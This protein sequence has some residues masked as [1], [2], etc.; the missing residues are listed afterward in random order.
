MDEKIRTK[1]NGDAH[2]EQHR[3]Y[4]YQVVSV[5]YLFLSCLSTK[6]L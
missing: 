6:K 2:Y 5:D 3:F 1:K 4:L